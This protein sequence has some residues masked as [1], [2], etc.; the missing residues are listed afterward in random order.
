VNVDTSDWFLLPG[1]SPPASWLNDERLPFTCHFVQLLNAF[2]ADLNFG[3]KK[4]LG[5]AGK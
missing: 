5:C 3:E 4:N 1:Q 2:N